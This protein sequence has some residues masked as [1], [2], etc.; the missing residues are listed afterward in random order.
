MM[1]LERL[2]IVLFS[3]LSKHGKILSFLL[4]SFYMKKHN[5]HYQVMF[6]I[7]LLE[8]ANKVHASES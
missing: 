3:T 4:L 6:A 1:E 5:T 2:N 8:T 7:E